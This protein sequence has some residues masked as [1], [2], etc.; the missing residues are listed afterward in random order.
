VNPNNENEEHGAI[1]VAQPH[2][3]GVGNEHQSRAGFLDPRRRAHAAT[4]RKLAAGRSANRARAILSLQTSMKPAILCAPRRGRCARPTLA[5][6]R[7]LI[8]LAPSLQHRF[9]RFAQSATPQSLDTPPPPTLMIETAPP[10]CVRLLWPT[11]DPP[12]SLQT[13][14]NLAAANWTPAAPLPVVLGSNNL[15]TNSNINS[16]QF[17]RLSDP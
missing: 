1:D 14:T 17:Y 5:G 11:S 10:A 6:R 3:G 4:G 12:F 8:R 9:T 2:V 16:H 7:R 13:A 15:V